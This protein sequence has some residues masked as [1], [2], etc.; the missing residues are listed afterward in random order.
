MEVITNFVKGIGNAIAKM[1]SNNIL[2]EELRKKYNPTFTEIMENLEDEDPT[3]ATM[4]LLWYSKKTNFEV[5][6]SKII[7][8]SFRLKKEKSKQ[9]KGYITGGC[10]YDYDDDYC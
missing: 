4:L 10:G 3:L 2:I 6:D 8:D 9:K 7:E 5:I 1:Q